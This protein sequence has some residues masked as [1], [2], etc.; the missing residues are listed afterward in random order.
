[1]ILEVEVD[2]FFHFHH[3]RCQMECCVAVVILRQII[4]QIPHPGFFEISIFVAAVSH[5]SA[6]GDIFKDL[7]LMNHIEEIPNFVD[8]FRLSLSR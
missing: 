8:F 1:M 7:W 4:N 6:V 3:C 5:S 2:I